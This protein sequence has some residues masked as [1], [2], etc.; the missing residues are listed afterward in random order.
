MRM[1]AQGTIKPGTVHRGLGT[2]KNGTITERK[3]NI[4][5]TAQGKDKLSKSLMV[6]TEKNEEM[7]PN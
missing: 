4:M 1:P 6:D 2:N 5:G 3:K 7:D